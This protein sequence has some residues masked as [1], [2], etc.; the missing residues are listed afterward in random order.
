MIDYYGFKGN[1]QTLLI[2]NNL[3]ILSFHSKNLNIKL[4]WEKN[5]Y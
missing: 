2:I 1:I 4:I 5:K 3:L